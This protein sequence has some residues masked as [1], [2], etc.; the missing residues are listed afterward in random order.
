MYAIVL[1]IL[2]VIMAVTI[3]TIMIMTAK[4]LVITIV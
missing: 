1:V 3:L 4:I 2:P